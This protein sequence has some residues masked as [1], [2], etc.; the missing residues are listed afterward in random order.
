MADLP[1]PTPPPDPG[2]DDPA[3]FVTHT[4]FARYRH[5]LNKDVAGLR[6][7]LNHADRAFADLAEW[8]RQRTTANK[9]K[10]S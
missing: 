3:A 2:A 5:Y 1:T 6:N 9:E 7:R 8:L 10:T 4:D